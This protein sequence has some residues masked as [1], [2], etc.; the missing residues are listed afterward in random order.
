MKT[1]YK[2]LSIVA[3]AFVLA[4]LTACS[5]RRQG[6]TQAPIEPSLND[7]YTQ[8]LEQPQ[9]WQTVDMPISFNLVSPAKFNGSGRLTMV[10]GQ[11]VKV[12]VR[13]L[14]MEMGVLFA[15]Q[16]SLLLMVKPLKMAYCESMSHF[17][18][19]SGLSLSDIQ[20]VLLGQAFVPRQGVMV[21]RNNVTAAPAG[22]NVLMLT[23]TGDETDLV[24]QV[25]E[26]DNAPFMFLAQ[27]VNGEVNINVEYSNPQSGVPA[28]VVARNG[29]ATAICGVHK[30]EAKWTIKPADGK[31]NQITTLGRPAVPASYRRLTTAELVNALKN[32]QK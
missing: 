27:G 29:L 22:D 31:W 15:D 2:L 1:G 8:F 19:T 11:A 9:P 17:T 20:C 7:M 6:A 10:N 16:D 5:S 32:L 18:E 12:S 24:F 21:S 23:T 30:A 13:I 25:R 4:L 3:T 14:G 28:G 26:L